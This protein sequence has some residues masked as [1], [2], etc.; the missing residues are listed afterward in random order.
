VIINTDQ[1]IQ[2]RELDRGV[3]II[4]ADDNE[5]RVPHASVSDV[6][7]D[8]IEGIRNANSWYDTGHSGS[9]A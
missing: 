9:L 4:L 2:V 1:M 7:D 8:L 3:A 6:F 5:V